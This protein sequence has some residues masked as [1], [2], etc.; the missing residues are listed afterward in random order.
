MFGVQCTQSQK[1]A[2]GARPRIPPLAVVA[3]LIV[4]AGTSPAV[5]AEVAVGARAGTL[6]IGPEVV[7]G[8]SQQAHLRLVGGAYSYDTT[9]DATG[10]DYDGT[11]ELRNALLLLDWHPG[12][13]GFR[14]TAGGGW[15]DNS[16]KVSAP[17]EEFARREIPNLPALPS[18]LGQ[19]RGS[20][21]GDTLVP[22]L[23]LGWS[24][25]FSGGRF[26]MN[27]DL[28]ALYLGEPE[29]DLRVE[30]PLL[31]G[32]PP[33]ARPLLDAA[34]VVEEQR[35]EDELAD[36]RYRPVVSFGFTFKL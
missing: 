29:V 31:T 1:A 27:L 10:I 7:F 23:G 12:G 2:R 35:L 22:Y 30:S 13:G 14:F 19:V 26:G 34:I 11:F 5:S 24:R 3:A 36:Y 25:P 6:G 9:Y 15:N 28:G 33:A 20:A 21:Q 32:L 16:L 18:G 17:I 8:L 4:F